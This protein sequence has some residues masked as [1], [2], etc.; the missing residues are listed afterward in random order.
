VTPGRKKGRMGKKLPAPPAASQR[1]QRRKTMEEPYLELEEEEEQQKVNP[2]CSS[3]KKVTP[4]SEN[5]ETKEYCSAISFSSKKVQL[6]KILNKKHM[7]I[8]SCY[9]H[10]SL[11]SEKW[12]P[13]HFTSHF[14]INKPSP[15]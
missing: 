14:K 3:E 1:Q 9:T 12:P 13:F 7:I 2:S 5:G 15:R 11:S 8:A 6:F 10:F 4:S